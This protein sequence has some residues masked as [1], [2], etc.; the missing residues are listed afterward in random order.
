MLTG[1]FREEDSRKPSNIDLS[2]YTPSLEIRGYKKGGYVFSNEGLDK[3]LK[4]YYDSVYKEDEGVKLSQKISQ[5]TTNKKGVREVKKEDYLKKYVKTGYNG[6]DYQYINLVLGVDIFKEVLSKIQNKYPYPVKLGMRLKDDNKQLKEIIITDKEEGYS[7]LRKSIV[8]DFKGETYGRLFYFGTIVEGKYEL[9]FIIKNNEEKDL[10]INDNSKG[11]KEL[12]INNEG[13]YGIEVYE[14]EGGNGY[15]S[16]K[17]TFSELDILEKRLPKKVKPNFEVHTNGDIFYYQNGEKVKCEEFEESRDIKVVGYDIR[18]EELIR[19]KSKLLAIAFIGNPNKVDYV[20][21]KDSNYKNLRLDNL[22][23]GRAEDYNWKVRGLGMSINKRCY[24]CS[25]EGRIKELGFC[26]K[27]EVLLKADPMRWEEKEYYRNK[28]KIKQ[29]VS[30]VP[31][32]ELTDNQKEKMR[33]RKEGKTYTEISEELGVS[34]QVVYQ[35]IFRV[36]S[37][38]P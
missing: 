8:K 24:S 4:D 22:E 29:G 13:R 28:L 14:V 9:D 34:Y 20:I 1:Y 7:K 17:Y 38:Y 32:H 16:Q 35:S 18:G 3:G 23:W 21:Y 10:N 26:R 36:I 15:L 33:L 5:I 11:I 12:N 31:L 27:C 37:K 25:K 6:L 30:H 2:L 19:S